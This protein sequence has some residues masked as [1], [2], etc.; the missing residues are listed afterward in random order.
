METNTNI[1]HIRT[2]TQ[3][4]VLL[5]LRFCFISEEKKNVVA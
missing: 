3:R 4:K 5:I 1:E 2:T